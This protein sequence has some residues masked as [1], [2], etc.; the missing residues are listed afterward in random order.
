MGLKE[1]LTEIE[2]QVNEE[3]ISKSCSGDGCRVYLTGTPSNRVIVNLEHEFEQRKINTKRCDYVLFCGD[4]SQ[5]NLVVVLVELK[6]GT[7]KTSAVTDQLQGGADFVAE[8][9]RKLPKEANAAL[10]TFK[11]TCVPALFHGK[12][13]DR[14]ELSELERAKIRFLSQKPTIKRRKCGEAKNLALVLKG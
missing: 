2:K 8:M 11:I 7:F 12:R 1:L 6:S 14:F 5:S 4:T 9:F 13:I 10:S 3:C